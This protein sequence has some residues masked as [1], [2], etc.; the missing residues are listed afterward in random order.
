M[1]RVAKSPKVARPAGRYTVHV[2]GSGPRPP[3]GEH[4][5]DRT[6]RRQALRR[7]PSAR[8]RPGRRGQGGRRAS[9]D[10]APQ[11][12]KPAPRSN[13]R[14]PP[15]RCCRRGA[16]R[17]SSTPR[18]WRAS[19]RR[20]PTAV[21]GQRRGDRRQADRQ[22]PGAAG[23]GSTSARCSP[24]ARLS[25]RRPPVD[26]PTLEDRLARCRIAP[27]R[28]GRSAARARRRRHRPAR[29]RTAPCARRARSIQF[30]HAARSGPVP[31]ALRQ[32]LAERQRPG[33]GAARVA[34][35]RHRGAR[36]RDRRA[37]AAR[38]PRAVSSLGAADRGSSRRLDP[39]L[40]A[41]P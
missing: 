10:R 41:T 19:R 28:A 14:T 9:A 22:R 2:D 35:P 21:Q 1:R 13:C 26:R 31:P 6:S 30:S 29:H 27:G 37:V 33:R 15:P 16:S 18:R 3:F 12:P 4:H 38:R 39:G 25:A 40:R 20:S 8:R 34:G 17:A 7:R 23:Q 24:C 32:R 36:P 5:E 11:P